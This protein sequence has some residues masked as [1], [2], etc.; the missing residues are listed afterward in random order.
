V[1]ALDCFI[2]LIAVILLIFVLSSLWAG[3]AVDSNIWTLLLTALGALGLKQ[4]PTASTSSALKAAM[5]RPVVNLIPPPQNTNIQQISTP[6][7]TVPDS[8]KAP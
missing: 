8:G 1:D 4:L 3:H 6:D 2:M 7:K 5:Q